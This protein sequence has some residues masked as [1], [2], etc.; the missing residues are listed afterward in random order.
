MKRSTCNAMV[1]KELGRVPL[2]DNRIYH[3]VKFWFKLLNT[4]NTILLNC[5][6]QLKEN[7]VNGGK[8]WVAT[9]REQLSRQGFAD[10]WSEPVSSAVPLIKQRIVDQEIQIINGNLSVMRKA[11]V[12]RNIVRPHSIAGHLCKSIP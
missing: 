4:N 2:R 5:Y 1:Y 8:N 3:V 11:T 9:V 12:Y 7:A 10:M 6:Y